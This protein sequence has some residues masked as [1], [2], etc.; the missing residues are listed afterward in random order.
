MIPL[1]WSVL[2]HPERKMI[3]NRFNWSSI[4]GGGGEGG[5]NR[6]IPMH[7]WRRLRVHS[8]SK[9]LLSKTHYLPEGVPDDLP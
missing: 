5:G 3:S 9:D 4:W 6:V 2:A 7:V 1:A 8:R